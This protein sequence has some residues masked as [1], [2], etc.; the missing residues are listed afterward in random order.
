MKDNIL[1]QDFSIENN[2]M[3]SVYNRLCIMHHNLKKY[4]ITISHIFTYNGL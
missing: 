2:A 3:M 1:F 4:K